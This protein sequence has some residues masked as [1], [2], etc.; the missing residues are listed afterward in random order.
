M[1]SVWRQQIS[2]VVNKGTKLESVD[3]WWYV[4]GLALAGV[5]VTGLY[6]LGERSVAVHETGSHIEDLD[7][8]LQ[9]GAVTPE[10]YELLKRR[11]LAGHVA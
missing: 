9:D 10:E 6:R 8:L 1:L 5:V 11:M 3:G 2:T 7:H 4:A